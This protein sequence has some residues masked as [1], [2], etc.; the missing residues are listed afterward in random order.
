MPFIIPVIGAAFSAAAIGQALVG[1]AL[2]VG[3]SALARR[4][5]PKPR[6][7]NTAGAGMR[8]SLRVD[9]NTEREIIL[10]RAATAGS[11]V[12]WNTYGPNG[13]DNLQLVF[14]VAD[15]PC[16]II[17]RIWINGVLATLGEDTGNG[18]TVSQY[19]GMYI[20]FHDG[21]WDQAADSDLVA[22]S[23]GLWTSNHRGRGVAYVRVTMA[24]NETLYTNGQ[25]RFLFEILGAKLYDIRRDSTAG[26]SGSHR[27][28]DPSTYEWS[29]N[30]VVIE[31]NWR[32]GIYVN[33]QLL[34]GMHTPAAA[35]PAAA[36][37]AAANACDET[38]ALKSG[39][40]EARYRCGGIAAVNQDNKSVLTDIVTSF[41]GFEIDTGGVIVPKPAVAQ[42]SVMTITDD[43]LISDG[44]VEITP[45]LPRS[46]LA[47]AT[48]GTYH[49]PASAYEAISLPPRISPDDE[50]IDGGVHLPQHY[51]LDYVASGTQG[52]RILEVFRRRDRWQKRVRIKLRSRFAVL[53]SGDWITWNSSRY[54]IDGGVFE[55]ISL[56]IGSDLTVS[57]HLREVSSSIYTWTPAV[58][59]LDPDAP[60]TVASGGSTFSAIAG[61]DVE[62]VAIDGGGAATRPGI[63]ATW[64]AVTDPTVQ[65]VEFEYR[66]SGDTVALSVLS[67]LPGGGQYTWVNGVQGEAIY[68]VRARPIVLPERPVSWTG[69]VSTASNTAPQVVEVGAITIPPDTVTAEMLD[70]QTRFELSLVTAVD[71]EFGSAAAD[72]EAARQEIERAAAGAITALIGQD[73]AKAQIKV[74]QITRATETSALAS[75]ITTVATALDSNVA[76]VVVLQTSVNGISANWA[77]GIDINGYVVGTVKL[78]GSASGSTFDVVADKFRVALPGTTGGGV[79]PVFQ[80][81]NVSGS[82]K[83]VLRGD[84]IA[85]GAIIAR[86]LAVT[87]LSSIVAN[88]GV[89]T[90]GK[91]QSA[92]GTCVFDLNAKRL[93]MGV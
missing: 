63:R 93:R 46:D 65:S 45:R 13:N 14:A 23:G 10:G 6:S 66:R 75:Q 25:P 48:F 3:L 30:P 81:S 54:G 83:L 31:Y 60:G 9:P 53:E 37:I 22:N 4:L 58:D 87:S 24:Y 70:A 41:G 40:T 35:L 11:L 19:P 26:G 16:F 88:L 5:S 47:N 1:V 50:A 84:M 57:V 91:L 76:A 89:I 38:V 32:R 82:P 77:V 79:V 21:A 20:K 43:D 73:Q 78:D 34:A 86:S 15:H 67:L 17:D 69:W 2:S 36:W 7:L 42:A 49:E 56:Q 27:W 71:T 90:A 39:G 8:L 29:E 55:V 18:Y 85:D 68:E 61:L 62:A 33:G 12:W 72:L 44:D 92:D 74:E 59:E 28:G 64:T 51:A 80:I 52:Q